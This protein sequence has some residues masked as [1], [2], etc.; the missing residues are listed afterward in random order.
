[1]EIIPAS[2]NKKA[3]QLVNGKIYD[4]L[5]ATEI[6]RSQ[7]WKSWGLKEYWDVLKTVWQLNQSLP[8]DVE[9][10]RIIGL[11]PDW[12]MPNLS[13]LGFSQDSKG[14][15]AFWEKFRVFSAIE[16]FPRLSNRDKLMAR[17]VEKEIINKHQKAVIWIG[18]NHTLI[19]FTPTIQRN[20]KTIIT[21][22]RFAFLLSQKYKHLFFQIAF[23]HRMEFNGSD[24]SCKHTI[25][26]FLDSV[27]M[28]RGNIP[29]GFTIAYSPF[30][31]LRDNCLTIFTSYPSLCYGDIAEGL[32][33]IKP[34]GKHT[35]CTW[36]PGYISNEMFMKYK[37]MYDLIFGKNLEIKF[38]NAKELNRMLVKYLGKE[39]NNN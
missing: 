5:L 21:N 13:L 11:D 16:D 6:A 18:F 10:M 4:S 38:K 14:K 31:K 39:S 32:I 37:P 24:G 8:K 20:N 15:T 7:C 19:N 29:A 12:E 1:M 26:T 30:E 35:Q 33:F 17:N 22:P 2:M 9:K 34:V 28:K 3:E 23:H 25:I 27:M 36:Q